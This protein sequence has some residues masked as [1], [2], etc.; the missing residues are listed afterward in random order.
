MAGQP[1]LNL[2]VNL[3]QRVRSAGHYLIKH[4]DELQFWVKEA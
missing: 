1:E 3:Y 2:D 4:F